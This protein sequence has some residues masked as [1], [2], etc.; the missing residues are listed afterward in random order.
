MKTLIL[1][2]FMAVSLAVSAQTPQRVPATPYPIEV[3]QPDSTVLTIRLHG[4]ERGHFT[5]TVDGYTIVKNRKGY[6]CYARVGC[7]GRFV[8]TCRVARDAA[9]RSAADIKYL[10]K[11]RRNPK[12]YRE[13]R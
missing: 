12:L 5:T 2:L 8:A 7:K 1:M 4:D 9:D 3:V 13:L 6:Y 10:E 11:M